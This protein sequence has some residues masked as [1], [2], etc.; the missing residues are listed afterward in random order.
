[1]ASPD[2]LE[3]LAAYVPTPVTRTIYR[4]PRLLTEP[5]ARRFPAAV[6]YT[7]IS[8]F[9]PLTE[10]LGQAGPTGAEELTYLI[11]QY[12]T[13]MIQI[14]QA[15]HGQVVKFSGDALTV[16]FP[17]E[18]IS[19]QI[20]V[21]RA[22]ECAWAMQAKMSEFSALKTSRGLAS[23]SLK[24]GIG[25]GKILECHIG[26]ALGHWEYMVSGAPL[27]QVAMAERLAEPGQT[28]FSPQAW[29]EGHSFFTG[30]ANP[31][32]PDFIILS[33]VINSLPGSAPTGLDW[34]QLD[35][36]ESD[37]AE[38]A[39]RS[40]L[41]DAVKDRLSEQAD[42]LAELRRVTVLFIGVGGFDYEAANALERL[43]NFL[44]AIQ[45]LVHRFEGSLNKVAVDDKGTVLLILFGVPPFSHEDDITR[46]VACALS[47]ETV[48]REQGLRMSIGIAEGGLFAGPVGAPSR[49]EYTVIGDTVN[50]A[51]RLMQ[52][53]KAS[54]ILISQ[55]VK[56]RAGPQFVFESMGQISVKGRAE[57]L[58]A[59]LVKGEQ[60]SQDEFIMRYLLH[61]EPLVGR[62]SE[63]E[64]LRQVTA[65]A[66][67]EGLQLLFI[68][69]ELGLGKSRLASEIVREWIAAGGTGYGSKC[70]SYGR[71]TPYQAWREVLAA[72]CSLTPTLSS[73][74]QL[75]RL[76]ASIA[77]LDDPPDQPGYW[78]DRLPL[79]ADVLGVEAPENSFTQ[80]ITGQLRRN[81][82]FALIA[83]LLRH[84]ARRRFLLILL[85]DIHW[86][87]E[88]SLALVAYLAKTLVDASLLLVLV[89]RPMSATEMD[90]L[91]DT[92]NLPY[93]H[94]IDLEPLSSPE[95][96]ELIKMM[97]GDKRLSPDTEKILLNRGQGNPFFL[98]EIAGAILE[99]AES[100]TY[101]HLNTLN[102]PDTVQDV[103]FTRVDRLSDDEKLT[104]KVA[105]VIGP[106]FQRSLLSA[107]HPLHQ[108]RFLLSSQL[109]DLEKEK[110]IRLEVPAPKWEYIFH[111]VITQE[112][113]YEGLLLA[114]RRQLHRA[115]GLAL[116]NLVPDEVEQLAFHFSRSDNREKALHYLKVAGDKARREYANYAAIGYYSEILNLLVNHLP[117]GRG[118]SVISTEYW[119]VLMERAKLFSLIG[120]RDSELEDLG[121]LGIMAEA[122]NDDYRRALAA[123]QWATLYEISADFDSGLEMIERCVQ[124][125]QKAG[126]ERLVGEAYNQWGRLLYLRGEYETAGDYLQN[127]LSIAQN[128]QDKNA[129]ADC[130]NNLGI[131]AH[132]QDD[133]D[134]ALYF[135]NEA[136]ALRWEMGDQVGLANDLSYLGQVYYD[137][138]Q[139]TAA[140]KCYDQSLALHRTIGDRAGEAL[141]RRNLG[142]V[143]RT[144]G[145]YPG[146]YT[147]FSEALATYQAIG[148][149][150]GEAH[151]LYQLGL[152]H[153][154][155]IEY[156]TA[157][158]FLDEA[159]EVLKELD[160][161]WV[162]G[163]AL[164][165]Y[166]WTLHEKG[167]SREAKKYF[168]EAL[169]IQRDT[170]QEVKMMESVAHLGR[171][172]LAANDFSLAETC[173]RR[174]LDFIS[175]KGTQGIEHPALV[176]LTCYQVLQNNKKLAQ[177]ESVLAQGHQ[178]LTTHAA[179]IDEPALQQSYLTNIPE[180]RLIRELMRTEK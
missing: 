31:N 175:A 91:A 24:A 11:N 161:A 122:L 77:E 65:K 75:A 28:I 59:Y 111:N 32:Q 104:L 22:G 174:A 26:G 157:L 180:N 74:R 27:V 128:H 167:Q 47:L 90:L 112:V 49:R 171:A 86:A 130:L 98:Q 67:R 4:Q 21:R 70:I 54:T 144:L 166:G 147:L 72:L 123:K 110:L 134:V 156:D 3:K 152:L 154:R 101:Q 126:D 14:V 55:R 50:L 107:V 58:A 118:N 71:Q 150:R 35:P 177:A 56:E 76:A 148:D 137:L 159:L 25:A 127:A 113:V 99:V 43:Q 162:L 135:F 13:S 9:T 20:A 168:E 142:K 158:T 173:A 176:Y 61:K 96:L 169:K 6:L 109:E 83:A 80:S 132:Y 66:R 53:G 88:L 84:H 89:H 146:A 48:A 140:Q 60:G 44:H 52:Y 87:D 165:Y 95:S 172:A 17:A 120:Q 100:Q 151:T 30:A 93:A 94:T 41:P 79:L 125:A 82:T 85:E 51:A 163:E 114:Q 129:Q 153:T 81:N 155:L 57:T 12:F 121:T 23:L 15:Y 46:A 45:E 131:V 138:G 164:T 37:L 97:L 170:H 33:K 34:S 108:S 2:L 10:M 105:A 40:Y 106:T 36:G 62:T 145:N 18:K 92:K 102:L 133:Y 19:L 160:D 124:L 178:Y 16:L 39:L 29:R 7:D 5:S 64:Q 69:G 139:L 42:W 103:I 119:D 149:R 179:Q 115:V 78:A 1:M 68:E 141:T 8:G 73:Q 116:E 63:L 136:V 117:M 143:H 38:K